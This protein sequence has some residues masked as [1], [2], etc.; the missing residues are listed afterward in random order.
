MRIL[1]LVQA[2]YLQIIPNRLYHEPGST[3]W[4]GTAYQTDITSGGPR[5]TRY[6]STIQLGRN[7]VVSTTYYTFL[8]H[9][10]KRKEPGISN[11]Q[12]W[13][14]K[15]KNGLFWPCMKKVFQIMLS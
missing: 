5:F 6:L 1:T 10:T 9:L 15:L 13:N 2:R 11:L 3:L 14:Y 7:T 4:V 8:F 12:K